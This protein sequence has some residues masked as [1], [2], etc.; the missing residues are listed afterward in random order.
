MIIFRR[1]WPVALA[2]GVVGCVDG[3][4]LDPGL[5]TFRLLGYHGS[6][7]ELV[8]DWDVEGSG[9]ALLRFNASLNGEP[10]ERC[11]GILDAAAIA[12]ITETMNDLDLLSRGDT[13]TDDR[14][15]P[16]TKYLIRATGGTATGVENEV[17]DRTGALVE[18]GQAIEEFTR[19]QGECVEFEWEPRTP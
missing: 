4:D 2:L 11:E 18:I 1:L 19:A 14:D 16:T 12:S 6:T 7:G 10:I 3:P 9:H 15:T 13:D 5:W 8:R 17:V